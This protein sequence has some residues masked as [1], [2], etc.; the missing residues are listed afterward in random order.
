MFRSWRNLVFLNIKR[1]VPRLIYLR[2]NIV[3]KIGLYNNGPQGEPGEKGEKGE[4]CEYFELT[5]L[6]E[7]TIIECKALM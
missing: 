6:C 3:I 1:F 7:C 5:F 4:R 2:K